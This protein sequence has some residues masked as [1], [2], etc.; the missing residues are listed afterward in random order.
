MYQMVDRGNEARQSS[1]SNLPRRAVTGGVV[2]LSI[3]RA[4]LN[5]R[6]EYS[7]GG[8]G[9]SGFVQNQRETAS[10]LDRREHQKG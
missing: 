6:K 1:L 9:G 4:T 8:D 7:G 5:G 3:K 2:E 10:E